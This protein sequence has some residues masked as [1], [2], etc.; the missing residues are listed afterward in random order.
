[1]SYPFF[2]CVSCKVPVQKSVRYDVGRMPYQLLTHCNIPVSDVFD[3]DEAF[4][5]CKGQG[6]RYA[7]ACHPKTMPYVDGY[8]YNFSAAFSG[9]CCFCALHAGFGSDLFGSA[10]CYSCKRTQAVV[11]AFVELTKTENGEPVSWRTHG[12]AAL[13][14]TIL[15]RIVCHVFGDHVP[16]EDGVPRPL[17]PCT[18]GQFE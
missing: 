10:G 18:A 9:Y 11:A 17:A 2:R 13:P 12:W 4:A 15:D 5:F 7:D 14:S 3:T 6:L 1:M 16:V 8:H